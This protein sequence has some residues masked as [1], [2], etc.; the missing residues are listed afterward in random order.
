VVGVDEVP[1]HGRVGD[2]GDDGGEGVAE[3][4]VQFGQGVPVTGDPDDARA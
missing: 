3:L 1:G 2:V 4:L